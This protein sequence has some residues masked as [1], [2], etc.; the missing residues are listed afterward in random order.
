MKKNKINVPKWTIRLMLLV[1][2]CC[3]VT[4]V[5]FYR[6]TGSAKGNLRSFF[7]PSL[8]CVM[9][10]IYFVM[11]FS[12]C[13]WPVYFEMARFRCVRCGYWQ[14]QDLNVIS[15]GC[16]VRL[17]FHSTQNT[18]HIRMGHMWIFETLPFRFFFSLFLFPF[19]QF[20]LPWCS[21]VLKNCVNFT[22]L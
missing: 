7:L 6:V 12:L 10:V 3:D 8:D 19:R 13:I 4:W 9:P 20:L 18:L 15:F 22:F 2:I 11:R 16:N 1:L 21:D 5:F 14:K 17:S